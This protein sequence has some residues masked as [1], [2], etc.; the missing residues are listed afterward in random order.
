[1]G[2]LD[3]MPLRDQI[4]SFSTPDGDLHVRILGAAL[5]VLWGEGVGPQDESGLIDAHREMLE[6][7]ALLKQEAGLIEGGLIT[8]D[9][10]DVEDALDA[11]Y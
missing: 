9:D 6:H 7:I 3:V 2:E 8:V 1:M 10:F 11:K 5:S 4:I